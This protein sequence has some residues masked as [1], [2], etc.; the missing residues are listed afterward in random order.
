M[1]IRGTT[2]LAGFPATF[3]VPTHCLPGN[4]G[5]SSENTKAT[6]GSF[7]PRRSICCSAF[8]PILSYLG[9]S[10]DAKSNVISASTVF[11]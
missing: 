9:L 8:R 11:Y 3:T 10:V 7:C 2:L 5:N 6:A 1:L 4:G